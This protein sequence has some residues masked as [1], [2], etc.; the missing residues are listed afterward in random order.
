M[1]VSRVVGRRHGSN[2]A[3]EGVQVIRVKS[4]RRDERMIAVAYEDQVTAGDDLESL[5][6]MPVSEL[7]E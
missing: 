1:R 2:A 4:W 5:G 3:G 6:K 7:A